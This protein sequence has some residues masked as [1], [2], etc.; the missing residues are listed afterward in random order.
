MDKRLG[1]F[2][3]GSHE[4]IEAYWGRMRRL[5]SIG[6]GCSVFRVQF[7]DGV[8]HELHYHPHHDEI[9]YVASGRI[10]QTIGDQTHIL[11]VGESAVIPRTVPH[12]A[13]PIEPNT[14]VIVVLAGE[15]YEYSRVELSRNNLPH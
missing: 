3:D 4:E 12:T 2:H 15:G 13:R 1:F 5:G 7:H 10:E 8:S 6:E 11:T 9:V 14:E